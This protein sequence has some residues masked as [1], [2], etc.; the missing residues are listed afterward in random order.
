MHERRESEYQ[1]YGAECYPSD[2]AQMLAFD[3]RY[4]PSGYFKT[5]SPME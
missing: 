1:K 5:K 4:C 2:F 3:G